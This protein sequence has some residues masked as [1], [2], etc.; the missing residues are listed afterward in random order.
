MNAQS[1][2]KPATICNSFV[3]S[4]EDFTPAQPI[5]ADSRDYGFDFDEEE[6]ARELLAPLPASLISPTNYEAEAEEA[7]SCHL[8][9]LL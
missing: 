3:I 7:E 9:F 1:L 6:L 2:T 5:Y 4:E 8:W